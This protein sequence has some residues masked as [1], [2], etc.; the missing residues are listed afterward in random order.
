MCEIPYTVNS[1]TMWKCTVIS[2]IV[3]TFC[4][5]QKGAV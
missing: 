3:L 5:V 2:F 4:Y 1:L